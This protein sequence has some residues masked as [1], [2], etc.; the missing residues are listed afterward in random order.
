[1][2]FRP[3]DCKQWRPTAGLAG[4]TRREIAELRKRN[5]W[6]TVGLQSGTAGSG[7]DEMA[8]SAL[9]KAQ[10]S[11]DLRHFFDDFLR[12]FPRFHLCMP[13]KDP[14]ATFETQLRER[15]AWTERWDGR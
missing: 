6:Q 15:R 7:H 11:A 13:K 10:F 5:L 4:Q 1:M 3:R 8:L 12:V 14:N 2:P 9:G